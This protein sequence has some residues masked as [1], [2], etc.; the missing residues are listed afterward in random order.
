MEPDAAQSLNMRIFQITM[1]PPPEQLEISKNSL[2][3][4]Y[5]PH[6]TPYYIYS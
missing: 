6:P 2:F 3:N 1:G 5:F 4:I